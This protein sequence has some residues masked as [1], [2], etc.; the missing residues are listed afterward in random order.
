MDLSLRWLADYVETGVTP[1]QFCDAMTM[2]GSKVECYNEEADYISNV[3]V[4]KI[5]KIENDEIAS[6]EAYRSMIKQN[7]GIIS[8][9]Y[10]N[11]DEFI[12]TF[13]ETAFSWAILSNYL[14]RKNLLTYIH[15]WDAIVTALK[16]PE[17]L[18]DNLINAVNATSE[19]RYRDYRKIVILV[20]H[21]I[22]KSEEK[23]PKDICDNIIKFFE[24][25]NY[26]LDNSNDI[27]KTNFLQLNQVWPFFVICEAMQ[28][29]L[30]SSYENK[31]LLSEDCKKK[32]V[33]NQ[34]ALARLILEIMFQN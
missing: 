14:D 29:L 33:D 20:L 2:S 10:G 25:I 4:G 3:V 7:R 24:R 22:F 16:E 18:K 26:K 12:D 23:E 15:S 27:D 11:V 8:D 31:V 34:K 5:I 6:M 21:S 13:N 19:I 1:K 28:L 32:L 17:K 9:P 30:I